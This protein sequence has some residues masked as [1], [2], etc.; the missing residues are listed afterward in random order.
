MRVWVRVRARVRARARAR[1]R[2]SASASASAS[3]RGSV[4]GSLKESGGALA[5]T[6]G[7]VARADG[8][9]VIEQRRAEVWCIVE[10]IGRVLRVHAHVDGADLRW[11]EGR[12][13]T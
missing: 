13:C 12:G 5:R 4:S 2:A 11:G 7:G 6:G 10:R 3:A 1:V 9:E 8:A